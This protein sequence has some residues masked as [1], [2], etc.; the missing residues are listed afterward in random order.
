M[1]RIAEIVTCAR[2]SPNWATLVPGYLGVANLAYPRTFR[3]R[4]GRSL[5]LENFHDLITAWIIFFRTEYRVEASAKVIV[6]AGANIGAFS[7]YAAGRAPAARI[8]ALEPFPSTSSRLR[9][10]IESNGLSSRVV[11]RAWALTAADGSRWMPFS[12]LP[13][14]SRN[15]LSDASGDD[16]AGVTVES[17]CLGTL[18][19]RE[20]IARIDLLKMDIEGAEHEVLLGTPHN[21]LSRI[22]TLALEYHPNAAKKTLFKGLNDAGFELMRD[23]FLSPNSGTAEFRQTRSGTVS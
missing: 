1:R 23:S 13:S 18:F 8:I 3:T 15:I 2:V 22:G 17:V 7:L 16:S 4:D 21:I 19:E 14:Q 12:D 9:S 20:R 5:V 11:Q 10:T 6:D